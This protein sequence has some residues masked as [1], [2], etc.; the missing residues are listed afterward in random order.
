MSFLNLTSPCGSDHYKCQ[1]RK[2]EKE[3]YEEL[4]TRAA[5]LIVTTLIVN[6]TNFLFVV[7]VLSSLKKKKGKPIH[8]HPKRI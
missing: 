3:R 7:H 1:K 4:V 6:L 2:K 5:T 8:F